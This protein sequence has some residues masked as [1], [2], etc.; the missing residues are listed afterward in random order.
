MIVDLCPKLYYPNNNNLPLI[1]F[2]DL[3]LIPLEYDGVLPCIAVHKP[4]KYEVKNCGKIPFTSTFYWDP[5]GK[6]GSFSKVESPSNDIES[7]I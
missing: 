1:N 2:P 6:E 7:V 3:T 5:Y 4:T